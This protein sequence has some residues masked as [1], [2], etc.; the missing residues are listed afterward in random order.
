MADTNLTDPRTLLVDISPAEVRLEP[1]GQQQARGRVAAGLWPLLARRGRGSAS[2]GILRDGR[3]TAIPWS[4][5][6]ATAGW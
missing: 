6:I 1:D 2:M 4:P 3:Y 5:H